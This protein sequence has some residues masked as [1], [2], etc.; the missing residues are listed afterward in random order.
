MA[1]AV[2]NTDSSTTIKFYKFCFGSSNKTVQLTQ[3]QL[4]SIPYLTTFIA[5]K[6]DFLSC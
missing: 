3:Q 2:D 6:D 4:D 1:E 5:H